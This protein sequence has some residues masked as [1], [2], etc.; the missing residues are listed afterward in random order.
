MIAE[1]SFAQ[2]VG[3]SGSMS[4]ATRIGRMVVALLSIAVA[5]YSLRLYGVV[6]HAW[7][8]VDSGIRSVIAAAPLQA[9]THMLIAPLALLVGPLQFFP[10]LRARHLAFHRWSGRLYVVACLIGGVA[11]LLTAFHASGG[12]IAGLGFGILAVLWVGTTLG[13][14]LAV[15][16]R[17][18]ALHQ[19]LMRF[20]FALTFGAVTLRL[21][22]PIGFV[23]GFKSYQAMSVWLAYTS[24]IPNLIVVA[25]YTWWQA[26]DGLLAVQQRPR[27]VSA[28]G[29]R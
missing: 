28:G 17:R 29:D 21:Q 5:V 1:N 27:I 26:R 19:L 10:R 13:A 9:L 12:P 25:L 8:N 14:W 15:L 16:Q 20:S 6:A 11:A 24:W 22:I 23:L 3:T 18:I 2:T 4:F 7:I